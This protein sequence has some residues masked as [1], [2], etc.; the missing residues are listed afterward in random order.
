MKKNSRW[1]SVAGAG[2]LALLLVAGCTGADQDGDG[3]TADSPE[4]AAVQNAVDSTQ[5]AAKNAGNAVANTAVKAG[6]T[7]VNGASQ[8]GNAVANSAKNLD[9]AATITPAVKTALGAN[10]A[11][12]GSN[13]NVSTTDQNV[14]LEGTVKSAAQKTLAVQIAKKNAPGYTVV[15]KLKM[16]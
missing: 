10:A 12:K 11:L 3:N 5:N 1:I 6:E 4:G 16:G 15:D 2:T 14:T 8:A 13:I 9:D 7:V